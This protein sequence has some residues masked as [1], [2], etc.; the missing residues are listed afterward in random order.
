MKQARK[1]RSALLSTL[2][3]TEE[4]LNEI[5]RMHDGDASK[6]VALNAPG[7]DTLSFYRSIADSMIWRVR[8]SSTFRVTF[9]P[10]EFPLTSATRPLTNF[11][12]VLCA[13]L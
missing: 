3:L 9:W 4:R 8:V 5:A 13:L 12:P 11:T 1:D 2:G 10:L 7:L 6:M